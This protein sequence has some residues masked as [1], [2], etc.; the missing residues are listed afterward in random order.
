MLKSVTT[1]IYLRITGRR[2]KRCNR[3]IWEVWVNLRDSPKNKEK[4]IENDR[5]RRTKGDHIV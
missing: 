1:S 4:N 5:V 3:V 2:E